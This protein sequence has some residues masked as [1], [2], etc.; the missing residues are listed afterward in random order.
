MIFPLTRPT[1]ALSVN[2]T[3]VPLALAMSR[4]PKPDLEVFFIE[5]ADEQAL[6]VAVNDGSRMRL[7]MMYT[8]SSS[9]SPMAFMSSKKTSSSRG[10]GCLG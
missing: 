9:S 2:V 6:D 10:S 3:S 4:P 1:G 8:S 7:L 5:L